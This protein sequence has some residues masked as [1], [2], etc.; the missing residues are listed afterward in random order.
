MKTLKRKLKKYYLKI[1]FRSNW[2]WDKRYK[3][4]G[5]S[6]TGSYNN[7]AEFKA[8]IVNDLLKKYEVK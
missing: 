3:T 7:I 4:G 1:R 2:Y 8:K 5:N 6:G